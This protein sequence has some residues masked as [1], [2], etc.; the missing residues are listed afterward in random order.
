MDS[1]ESTLTSQLIEGGRTNNI[2]TGVPHHT[3]A[4]VS[5]SSCPEHTDSDESEKLISPNV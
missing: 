4:D 1:F 5:D 2:V 3:P